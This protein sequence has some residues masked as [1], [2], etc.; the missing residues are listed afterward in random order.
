[1]LH[2]ISLLSLHCGLRA[3][4]TFNLEWNDIDFTNDIILIKDTKSGRNRNAIMTKDVK[5]MFERDHPEVCVNP[6]F[7]N[8]ILSFLLI[9]SLHKLLDTPD[10]LNSEFEKSQRHTILCSARGL[11]IIQ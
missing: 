4:E 6:F 7:H 5:S 2:N 8:F 1:M 9:S 11:Y 10:F 3:G